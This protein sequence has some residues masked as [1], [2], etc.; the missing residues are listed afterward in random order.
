MLSEL[1]EA[2]LQ[3]LKQKKG[4]DEEIVWPESIDV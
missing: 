2:G 4:T 1:I 3:I